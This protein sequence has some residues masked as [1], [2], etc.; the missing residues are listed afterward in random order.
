MNRACA[1]LAFAS[2]T[3]ACG[4]DEA[5]NDPTGGGLGAGDG[6]ASGALS[7]HEAALDGTLNSL[8]LFGE[9]VGE[10]WHEPDYTIVESKISGPTGDESFMS[11]VYFFGGVD[12]ER[13][14]PGAQINFRTDWVN[15]YEGDELHVDIV[16]CQGLITTDL[17]AFDVL[18]DE[19]TVNVSA[20]ESPK[21]LRLSYEATFFEQTVGTETI[22][23]SFILEAP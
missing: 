13:L 18:A 14:I 16:G 7:V 22:S 12:H 11:L 15:N 17:W 4:N 5:I 2:L 9:A 6:I 19:V 21:Q 23:G 8:P 1:V 20:T 10:A 3:V